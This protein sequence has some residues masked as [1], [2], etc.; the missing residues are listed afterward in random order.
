M[1]ANRGTRDARAPLVWIVFI[2]AVPFGLRAEFTC[3]KPTRDH[4]RFGLAAEARKS[5]QGRWPE[6]ARFIYIS[7]PL[8]LNRR[9]QSST[10]FDIPFKLLDMCSGTQPGICAAAGMVNVALMIRCWVQGGQKEGGIAPALDV[11][12]PV[13]RAEKSALFGEQLFEKHFHG[14]P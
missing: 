9:F 8:L 3:R 11:F 13:L 14:F 7:R 10:F 2:A 6:L 1:D 12:N 5:F 4:A